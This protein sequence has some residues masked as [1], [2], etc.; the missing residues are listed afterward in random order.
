MSI[1][2]LDIILKCVKFQHKII[3]KIIS[4][5]ISVK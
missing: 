4:N 1:L 2:Q 3:S 5:S